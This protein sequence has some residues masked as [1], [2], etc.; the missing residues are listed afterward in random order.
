MAL[1]EVLVA[2]AIL[3]G[4]LLAFLAVLGDARHDLAHARERAEA[5]A[6]A[7][8]VLE[9]ART[10]WD[11]GPYSG[12]RG[13]HAWVLRCAVSSEAQSPRLIVVECTVTVRPRRGQGPSVTLESA[14]AR[15]R[16]FSRP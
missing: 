13:A 12:E 9:E 10:T 6:L 1:M 15:P 8:A 2:S 11:S 5:A 16:S 4:A 14:W 7:S 3:A